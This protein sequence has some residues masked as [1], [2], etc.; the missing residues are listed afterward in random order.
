LIPVLKV[1]LYI[2]L[3]PLF[4]NSCMAARIPIF[5]KIFLGSAVI[6]SIAKGWAVYWFLFFPRAPVTRGY[7]SILITL[8]HRTSSAS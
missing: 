3:P 1:A 8:L 7:V 2:H 6:H 4:R 5:E